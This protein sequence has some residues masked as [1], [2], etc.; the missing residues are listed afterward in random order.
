MYIEPILTTEMLTQGLSPF[1][2]IILFV[3]G[4]L[5]AKKVINNVIQRATSCTVISLCTDL[6]YSKKDA[7][8]AAKMCNTAID[9][10]STVSDLHNDIYKK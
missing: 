10:T 8:K 6:G 9:L 1:F 7:K 3:T 4:V 5:A 2:Y